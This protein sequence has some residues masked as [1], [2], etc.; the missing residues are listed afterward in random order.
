[1]GLQIIGPAHADLAVL[2][3]GHAYEL[4]SGVSATGSPLLD[5]GL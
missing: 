4:A 2:Q 3:V 1:M 5:K